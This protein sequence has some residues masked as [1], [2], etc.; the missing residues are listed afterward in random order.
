MRR[1]RRDRARARERRGRRGHRLRQVL[2]VDLGS[3]VPVDLLGRHQERREIEDRW[4]DVAPPAP[5]VVRADGGPTKNRPAGRETTTL[6]CARLL[7]LRLRDV[8]V[9]AGLEVEPLVGEP[10]VAVSAV[11]DLAERKN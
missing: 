1:V 11:L 9:D 2:P 5:P 3:D 10:S 7:G 4:L 6:T 8:D